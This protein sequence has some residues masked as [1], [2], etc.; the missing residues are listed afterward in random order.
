M[1]DYPI[2][3]LFKKIQKINIS[4]SGKQLNKIGFINK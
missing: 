2:L 3:K 1:I 4:Q